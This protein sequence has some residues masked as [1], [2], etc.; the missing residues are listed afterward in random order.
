MYSDMDSEN[1]QDLFPEVKTEL[2]ALE[3]F[4][5]E[6]DEL[7]LLENNL[8]GF[9]I[10]EAIGS[11]RRELRHSDFI[12]FIFDP[13]ENHGLGGYALKEFLKYIVK[14]NK[15]FLDISVIDVDTYDLVDTELRRE[16]KNIDILAVSN[17]NKLV[18][19]IE[20]KI[21][22]TEH[23]NQLTKY[24]NIVNNEYKE[25]TKIFIYLT[26]EGDSTNENDN[27]IPVSYSDIYTV[28]SKIIDSKS[29]NIGS[30]VLILLKHYNEMVNRHIMSDNQISDLCK[31]IYKNHRQALDLIFEHKPDIFIEI[32]D[33]LMK[34]LSRD[35]N[36]G[37]ELDH[38]SKSYVRF[39]CSEWDEMDG[40]LSGSGAWTKT[41][42]VLLFEFTNYTD[43]VVLKLIIGPGDK[44]FRE[45]LF[46]MAGNN[47]NVFAGKSKSLY[48]K[49]TMIYKKVFITK[50]NLESWDL[51]AITTTLEEKWLEFYTKD[52]VNLKDVINKLNSD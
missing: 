35:S 4:V 11:I 5:A 46:D 48:G 12:K 39:F 1:Y 23:S 41:N 29:T 7:E 16:W 6:N 13:S 34:I 52:Y 22:T 21:D 18:V 50:K 47:T 19:C 20:N 44:E 27:W 51:E 49:W 31:K 37:I 2:E 33:Y 43:G 26:P 24:E 45:N 42:R 28:V 17:A 15:S 10:F 36:E 3:D 25:F 40:N 14:K 8:S 32:K 9:N 38:C 30:D